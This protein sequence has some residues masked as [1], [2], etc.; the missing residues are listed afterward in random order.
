LGSF[1]ETVNRG[2]A[3]ES[4]L[5]VVKDHNLHCLDN[6]DARDFYHILLARET[7]DHN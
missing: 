4:A 3:L 5:I 2:T 1:P 7:F 6:R